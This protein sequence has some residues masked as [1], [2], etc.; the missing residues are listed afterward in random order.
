MSACI[1]PTRDKPNLWNVTVTQWRNRNCGKSSFCCKSNRQLFEPPVL[2]C[3]SFFQ[4]FPLKQLWVK[5]KKVRERKRRSQTGC[6]RWIQQRWWDVFNGS[7]LLTSL[8]PAP[9]PLQVMQSFGGRLHEANKLRFTSLLK[10]PQRNSPGSCCRLQWCHSDGS[11]GRVY[12]C[13]CR[14]QRT[15]AIMWKG[16]VL[17]PRLVYTWEIESID[18]KRTE[19]HWRTN[20]LF[21]STVATFVPNA[22]FFCAF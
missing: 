16:E 17:F 13:S 1:L 14:Y 10:Q 8:V 9:L 3:W 4:H 11:R 2:C 18:R 5:P 21:T 22:D 12:E 6:R 7:M 15:A 20:A 19:N